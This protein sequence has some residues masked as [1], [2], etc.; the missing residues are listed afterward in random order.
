MTFLAPIHLVIALAAALG[1]VALHLITRDRPPRAPLPTARFIPPR[2]E[3]ARS[4]ATRPADPLLLLLRV[5]LIVL[6]GAAFA[7]PVLEPERRSIARVVML[8]RSRAVASALEA[9]D[10]AT[11]WLG[12]GDALV[13]FDSAAR[14]VDGEAHDSLPALDIGDGATTSAAGSLSAALLAASRVAREL[15]EGADSIELVLISP[16]ADEELDDATLAIRGSWPGRVRLVRLMPATAGTL[17]STLEVRAGTDDPVGAAAAL[18]GRRPVRTAV[19]VVRAR[20]TASDSAVAQGGGLLVVWPRDT[21]PAGWTLRATI[22]TVGA[23]VVEDA[24][25]VAPFERRVAA[26]AASEPSRHARVAARWVDGEPAALERP[27]GP[28]CVRDVAIPLDERGDLALRLETRRLLTAL[29]E[30]CGGRPRFEPVT[31]SVAAMLAGAGP[32]A[33]SRAIRHDDAQ[34]TPLVPWLL[35]AVLLAAL[36]EPVVRRRGVRT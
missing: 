9:R 15:V 23:V 18:L 2:V 33:S 24:V 12:P 21:T 35:G 25:V 8:D 19:R 11:A 36:A 20:P 7:R 6:A 30:P 17:T 34:Q 32:L 3:K 16:L 13:L 5:V 10:S 31:D 27:I 29:T 1:I 26:P 14:V 28:G 4:R 22:D